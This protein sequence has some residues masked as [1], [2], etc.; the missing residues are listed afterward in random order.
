[1]TSKHNSLPPAADTTTLAGD[2]LCMRAATLVHR[3][4]HDA[5]PGDALIDAVVA[6]QG[7]IDLYSET[8]ERS[9]CDGFD[10]LPA[11]REQPCVDE[12]A[13]KTLRSLAE[14]ETRGAS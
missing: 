14:H 4:L 5:E 11:T 6:L 2:I 7:A 10:N 1:M 8:R 3:L 9:T 13:P 12:P